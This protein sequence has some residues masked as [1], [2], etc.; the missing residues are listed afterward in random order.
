[1]G[2]FPNMS[3]SNGPLPYRSAPELFVPN[4]KGLVKPSANHVPPLYPPRFVVTNKLHK[5]P[6]KHPVTCQRC[7]FILS[8]GGTKQHF[9]LAP[10]PWPGVRLTPGL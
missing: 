10:C 4:T 9:L 5:K 7:A 8:T 1:M 2:V 3:S 6:D